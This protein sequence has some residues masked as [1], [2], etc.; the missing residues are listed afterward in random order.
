MYPG[1]A[2]LLQESYKDGEFLSLEVY[3][4][5]LEHCTEGSGMVIDRDKG[6]GPLAEDPHPTPQPGVSF[7]S[8]SSWGRVLRQG[9]HQRI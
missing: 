6:W 4:L 8:L 2:D 3:K 7:C 1:I 9:L 5:S